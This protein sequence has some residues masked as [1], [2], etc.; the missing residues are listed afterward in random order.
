M[1]KYRG[2]EVIAPCILNLGTRWRWVVSFTPCLLYPWWKS[3]GTHWIRGWMGL[4]ASLDVV[5]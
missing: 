2:S 1:K 5:V 4:R 3:A